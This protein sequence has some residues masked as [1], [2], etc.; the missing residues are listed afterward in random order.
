MSVSELLYS[1]PQEPL[2]R[3]AVKF[4]I[5][6]LAEKVSL[7]RLAKE[8]G[9]SA[10]AVSHRFKAATG[11]SPHAV[12]AQLRMCKAE[13]LLA[14]TAIRIKEVAGLAGYGDAANFVKAFSKLHGMTPTAYRAVRL[15]CGCEIEQELPTQ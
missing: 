1:S 9:V 8:L 4:F 10:S 13:E 3:D 2:V 14:S 11:K 7:H 12:L 15:I 5:S 6:H